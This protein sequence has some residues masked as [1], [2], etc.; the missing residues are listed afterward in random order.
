MRRVGYVW[1]RGWA[2]RWEWTARTGAEPDSGFIVPRAVYFLRPRGLDD[3][4]RNALWGK[5]SPLRLLE[6]LK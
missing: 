6:R 5:A 4:S 2:G 3:H 1:A